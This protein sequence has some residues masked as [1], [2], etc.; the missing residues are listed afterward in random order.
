[1]PTT[2][3]L[4]SLLFAAAFIGTAIGA[5]SLRFNHIPGTRY[6]ST[7]MY[8]VAWWSLLDAI[9]PFAS[10]AEMKTIISQFSYIGI[11]I[12]PIA[13][14]LFVFSY[15]QVPISRERSLRNS[16]FILG[17]LYLVG[18]A[19]N[20][21]HH[22]LYTS[23]EIVEGHYAPTYH[24]GGLFWFW[25][26]CSYILLIL[27]T[28]QLVRT[29]ISSSDLFRTQITFIIISAFLPWIGNILYLTGLNPIPGFDLT[30][31]AFIGVG[32]LIVNAIFQRGLFEMIPVAYA[33][34]FKNMYDAAFLLSS[35]LRIIDANFA[36]ENM[37]RT[38]DWLGKS[39]EE[40]LTRISD[41]ELERL[42]D[43][44][45]HIKNLGINQSDTI[46]MY[47]ISP[48]GRKQWLS[49]SGT[50]I[51]KE[52]GGASYILLTVRDISEMRRSQEITAQYT[53]HLQ[54]V[55]DVAKD[56]L[57][58]GDWNDKIKTALLKTAK[59]F[60]IAH[61]FIWNLEENAPEVKSIS[62]I[63]EATK[64]LEVIDSTQFESSLDME[65]GRLLKGQTIEVV[66]PETSTTF[67][68]YPILHKATLHG[69]LVHIWN[70]RTPDEQSLKVLRIET[71]LIVAAYTR[72]L[73]YHEAIEARESAIK[74]S[75]A[76][77]EFLSMMS[78]EIR[79][80]LNAII[81]ISHLIEEDVPEAQ[82][83]NL[84]ALIHSTSHLKTLVNDILDFNKI[85]AGYV[86]LTKAPITLSKL[87]TPLSR[88][89]MELAHEN[90]LELIVD[91]KIDE[92]TQITVD[93][94]RLTQVIN[95][96]LHNAIKFTSSG[97]VTFIIEPIK[98]KSVSFRVMDTGPGIPED[99]L[100]SIFDK[101]TQLSSGND[102]S[103]SGTGLGLSISQRLLELMNSRLEVESKLGEG[104]TFSF[105][106]PNCITR[107][108]TKAVQTKSN[109]EPIL[110]GS[111]LIVEDNALNRTIAGKF[112]EKWGLTP[113]FAENGA[114]AL[115]RVQNENFDL[116][117]MDLQM[118]VM[119]GYEA[120]RI[121]RETHPNLPIIALTASAMIDTIDRAQ[122]AGM[123][124]YI[125]KPFQPEELKEKL[126]KFL[127]S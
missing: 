17:A 11:V 3:I 84:E 116:I 80:P 64:I 22:E 90:G 67:I 41:I 77:S 32:V 46:E 93:E 40:L 18:V 50:N 53:Q 98:K 37:L 126:V 30:P 89:Y 1:M 28:F 52:R 121:I 23:V 68:G 36:A 94:L 81:G 58:E 15:T 71:E 111:L 54:V 14:F 113:Q 88:S 119:D 42:H 124:D 27:A 123:N 25:A 102:R 60:Q 83:S 109:E 97:T 79:T 115:E 92:D 91:F 82:K 125:S 16:L 122:E 103:H 43:F 95:N 47:F 61:S 99:R 118:P 38:K 20:D 65:K 7:L 74:A 87:I 108:T 70:K 45:I 63:Q 59:D 127:K 66:K 56:L 62:S 4:Q 35:N 107:V 85:E 33:S 13:F 55:N 104:S 9:S 2:A 114:E 24:Y 19:T 39:P 75:Q 44:L 31:L 10:S 110:Q 72:E 34:L 29:A 78:H 21:F 5:Y 12:S 26:G 106:L 49:M 112:I 51:L 8:S 73:L 117:L 120:T 101:F 76:K 105:I 96:L 69:V 6:F 48:M 57:A 86:N 100:A